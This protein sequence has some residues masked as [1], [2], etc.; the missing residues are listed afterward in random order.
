MLLLH[1]IFLPAFDEGV[2]YNFP[3][4]RMSSKVTTGPL[5]S[6]LDSWIATA[7]YGPGGNMSPLW[8]V[9]VRDL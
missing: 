9:I 3:G 7:E 8:I 2:C 1:G 4:P 6:T 5:S